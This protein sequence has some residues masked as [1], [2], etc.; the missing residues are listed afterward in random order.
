MHLFSGH[1]LT[2]FHN[3]YYRFKRS[4]DADE[5]PV[6]TDL[7]ISVS[8]SMVTLHLRRNDNINP[9]GPIYMK[10]NGRIHKI[11]LPPRNVSRPLLIPFNGKL[12]LQGTVLLKYFRKMLRNQFYPKELIQWNK[13]KQ[14]FYKQCEAISTMIRCSSWV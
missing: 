13:S 8:G 7:D 5:L 10:R 6:E 2:H 3:T 11:D 1:T 12:Y 9:G 4:A 14:V